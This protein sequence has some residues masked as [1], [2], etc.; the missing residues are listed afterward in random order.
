MKF[1]NVV[2][3]I[4]VST[5]S[6]ILRAIHEKNTKAHFKRMRINDEFFSEDFFPFKNLV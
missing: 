1:L 5:T 3:V 4:I 2:G 6:V